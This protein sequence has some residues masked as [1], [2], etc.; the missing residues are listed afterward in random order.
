MDF[1]K[2]IMTMVPFNLRLRSLVA[3]LRLGSN[4]FP[5]ESILPKFCFDADDSRSESMWIKVLP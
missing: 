4:Y 3:I 2:G 5:Q 1:K